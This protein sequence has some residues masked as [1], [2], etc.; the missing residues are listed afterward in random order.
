MMF[1]IT[2]KEAGW[3]KEL[4]MMPAVPDYGDRNYSIYPGPG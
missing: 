2:G 4:R 3:P 1:V